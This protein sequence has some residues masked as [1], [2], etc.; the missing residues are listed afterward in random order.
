MTVKKTPS[1]IG[2]KMSILLEAGARR[3]S[4]HKARRNRMTGSRIS[5]V[6]G[7]GYHD[8][9]HRY[10]LETGQMEPDSPGLNMHRGTLLEPKI[11]EAAESDPMRPGAFEVRVTPSF[12]TP[13]DH[14]G[15]GGSPDFLAVSSDPVFC[16]AHQS[17]PVRIFGEIK[18]RD[19]SQR[20]YYKAGQAKQADIYQVRWGMWVTGADVGLLVVHI[21]VEQIPGYRI[22]TRD[23]EIEQDMR[24]AAQLF[25]LA[26]QNRDLEILLQ[27]TEQAET[28]K[29]I[30]TDLYHD[31]KPERIETDDPST[32]MMLDELLRLKTERAEL[33]ELI[34]MQEAHIVE[35]MGE[36]EVLKTTRHFVTLPSS[37][38]P[39]KTLDTKKLKTALPHLDLD[40]F[41]KTST[42]AKRGALRVKLMEES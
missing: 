24:K 4:W 19:S 17:L 32:E 25:R 39:R 22:I 11:L 26:V 5:D 21:G 36:A 2:W 28:R 34:K 1:Q 15:A 10:E 8:V 18:S 6:M 23:L 9:Y 12:V 33:Q 41:M 3:D 35:V 14:D 16:E 40:Q 29:A 27:L 37:P 30:L 31:S 13:P 20:W 42:P 38:N 7:S